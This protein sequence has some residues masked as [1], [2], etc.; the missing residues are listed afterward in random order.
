MS[1]LKK[2]PII[3]Q[4]SFLA[5]I[6]VFLM[7]VIIVSNYFRAS[8]VIKRDNENYFKEIISQLNQTISSNSDVIKRIIEKIS[9]NEQV[10][11]TYLNTMDPVEKYAA[12]KQLKSYITDMAG[13]KDGILDIALLGNDGINFNIQGDIDQ[14]SPM[15]QDIPGKRL[16]YYLGLK[17]LIYKYKSINVIV[18]GAPIY[19]ISNFENIEK[20]LGTLV[21]VLDTKALVGFK[22]PVNISNGSMVYMSDRQ[23]RIFYSNDDT[24]QLGDVLQSDRLT[25]HNAQ[26]II[27]KA[28]IPDLDGEILMK[29]PNKVLL[30]GLDKIRSQ[31]FSLMGIALLLLV[32]PF[33]FVINNILQPLKKLMR[34]MNEIKLGQKDHLKKRIEIDGYAEMIIMSSRFNQMMEK[35]EDL[36]V[37]LLESERMLY[38]SE[39]V[40]KQAELAYLQS[41][42][43]PHFL[44]NTLESIKGIAVEEESKRIFDLAKALGIFFR[45]S[46]K[47]PDIVPLAQELT[48]VQN[49]VYIQ[50]IRFGERLE[51]EYDFNVEVLNL[52]IPKMILQPIVENA[53]FHGIEPNID[54]SHLLLKGYLSEQELCIVVKDNGVGIE[55]DHL[56]SIEDTLCNRTEDIGH[57]RTAPKSI[58]L[59]N[60]NDRIRLTYGN[61]Y[62]ISISTPSGGGTQV[63]FKMP[64]RR[65]QHV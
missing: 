26:F 58:G 51:V 7:I 62:G 47:G 21:M 9:Y 38:E 16:Y 35:I 55:T 44:Y 46:I 37:L 41:Q 31:Q 65:E 48:I 33:L 3:F 50:K 22:N 56:K 1:F 15:V 4:L 54:K 59:I 18:V 5:S 10:V 24:A 52:M 45:F 60:V 30:Q 17:S 53:I 29:M 23:G 36:T 57:G 27:Q 11:Q 20:K 2:L 12:Y 14:L 13:M 6:I 25:G 28:S 63:L 61:E 43:N 34:L 32:I 39:L 64:I 8:E 42:I 49:Y 40:K 19:S